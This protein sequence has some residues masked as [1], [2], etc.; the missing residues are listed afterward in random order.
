MYRTKSFA[1][2]FGP[3][4]RLR[5]EVDIL[6][7]LSRAACS[8][9]YSDRHPNVLGYID[10]WEEEE[11]LYI[12]AELCA[13]GNY[14]HFLWEYGRHFPKLDEARVWKILSELSSVCIPY[15]WCNDAG[16]DSKILGPR[17][18]TQRRRHPPRPETR[19]YLHH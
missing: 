14:S 1:N 4:Q 6:K 9:G 16:I 5:E 11:T 19:E 7:H 18:H 2:Y 17:L 13:L 12:Q 10:S 8:A 3:S 15:S